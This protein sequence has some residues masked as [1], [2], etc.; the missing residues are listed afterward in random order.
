ML[1]IRGISLV[2]FFLIR[3]VPGAKLPIHRHRTADL[4]HSLWYRLLGRPWLV[5]SVAL[6]PFLW[7][8][9][10]HFAYVP[11]G[12]VATGFLQ[13]HQAYYMAN[14]RQLINDGFH[15]LYSLPSSHKYLF[16]L[17]CGKQLKS[18]LGLFS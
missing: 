14:A 18:I 10:A 15:L 2:T 6:V 3:M 9:R 13:Y 7:I 1:P 16:L 5:A 17:S 8:V 4:S 12:S 11:K